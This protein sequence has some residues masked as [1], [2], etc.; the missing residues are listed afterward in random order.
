MSG[1]PRAERGSTIGWGG[2]RPGPAKKFAGFPRAA[3][4]ERRICDAAETKRLNV[5]RLCQAAGKPLPDWWAGGWRN[6]VFLARALADKLAAGTD[7]P[8]VQTE[9]ALAAL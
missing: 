4:I 9:G 6:A 3:E 1:I 8:G 2:A 7:W 5:A